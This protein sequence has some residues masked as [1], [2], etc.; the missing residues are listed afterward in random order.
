MK[1]QRI[2]NPDAAIALV[3]WLIPVNQSREEIALELFDRMKYNQD[4]TFVITVMSGGIL[5]GMA[6]A[7]C[8]DDDVFLWQARNE[9]LTQKQVDIGF[10]IICDWAKKEGFNK[11]VTIPN[12]QAE[13]WIRRWGFQVSETGEVYKE[14]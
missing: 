1:Y 5:K 9:G 4:E 3:P 6:V 7:F 10:K 13:I 11:L 8:R 2:Y 14:I 12:R